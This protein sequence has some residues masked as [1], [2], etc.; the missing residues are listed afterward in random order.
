MEADNRAAEEADRKV[1]AYRLLEGGVPRGRLSHWLSRLDVLS[2]TRHLV[3]SG[4]TALLLGCVSLKRSV[5][6][7]AKDLYCSPL[8]R[9]RRAYAESSG[10]PWFILSA[11]HGL[12]DP[13][14]LLDPYDLS[15]TQLSA[16]ER[17]AWGERVVDALAKR[18]DALTRTIFEVHAGSHYRAAIAAPLGRRGARI[19]A[20]LA[21]LGLGRQLA[22]YDAH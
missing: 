14:E 3:D 12:V 11:L 20:P 19:E 15:L 4:A 18:L 21:H 2:P 17:R 9:R 7:P 8:W 22:W 1:R 5:P 10:R 16:A 13:D 6:A